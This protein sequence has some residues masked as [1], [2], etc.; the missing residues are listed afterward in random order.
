MINPIRH[1]ALTNFLSIHDEEAMT[2][3]ELQARTAG[4]VNELVEQVNEN[5]DLVNQTLESLPSEIDQAMQDEME[6]G[7]LRAI[8]GRAAIEEIKAD[9]NTLNKRIDTITA[10]GGSDNT[11]VVDARTSSSGEVFT[12]LRGRLNAIESGAA[13]NDAV[14]PGTVRAGR[15]TA[16]MLTGELRDKYTIRE[17]IPMAGRWN[18]T[19]YYDKDTKEL[20]AHTGYALSERIPCKYGDVFLLDSYVYGPKVCPAAILDA[21][22][23]V[24]DVQGTPGNSSWDVIKDEIHVR[25][26]NAAYIR[27]ICGTGQVSDF[28]AL[29]VAVRENPDREAAMGAKG[30]IHMRAKNRTNTVT[31]RAQIRCWFKLPENHSP[32]TWYDVP[33][34]LYKWT[35]LG[36]VTFRVFAATSNGTYDMQLPE[37]AAAYSFPVGYG[38]HPY[39]QVPTETPE[40]IPVTHVCFFVDLI[41]ARPDEYMNVYMAHLSMSGIP[42]EGYSLHDSLVNDHIS[43]VLPGAM[44]SPLFGKRILG[45]G[46]SLMAAYNLPGKQYSWFDLMCGHNGAIWHNASVAGQPVAGSGMVSTIASDMAQ[47]LQETGAYPDY[48]VVEGGAND[49]RLNHTITAFKH[50]LRTIVEQVRPLAPKCRILFVTNWRRSDYVTTPDRNAEGDYVVAMCEV[51]EELGI[52]VYNAYNNSIDLTNDY[53]AAWADEGIVAGGEGSLHFSEEANRVIAT[54]VGEALRRV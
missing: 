49:L 34:Q 25:H 54:Q 41:A 28:A 5:T 18:Y 35:N 4:K 52:P 15:L 6:N 14:R 50:S 22:G 45:V 42:G 31:D 13:F 1:V 39:F 7:N 16:G 17:F 38:I 2:A 11:E 8:V 10:Q 44:G 37:S 40:G 23:N 43:D 19:G 36:G 53:I 48:L 26:G 27:F 3:L 33:V 32:E 21:Q 30:F 46:D 20:T 51:A 24:L 29:R 12:V 9:F 47:C